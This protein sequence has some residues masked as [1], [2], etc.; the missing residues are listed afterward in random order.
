MRHTCEADDTE[1]RHTAEPSGL[2]A[3]VLFL[4]RDER[5]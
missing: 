2:S 5:L 1:P 3:E 4:L